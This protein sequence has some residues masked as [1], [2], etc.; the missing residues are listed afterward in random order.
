MFE[1]S[2]SDQGKTKN[3]K[4]FS[5]NREVY[6]VLSNAQP[7]QF[8]DVELEKKGE[9]WEW[10]SIKTAGAPASEA[11][12]PG[13]AT[14]AASQARPAEQSS[15][16]SNKDTSIARAVALKAAVDFLATVAPAKAGKG[17]EDLLKLSNDLE[18]YLLN[19]YT[20]KGLE[21]A[22]KA[23]TVK[24]PVDPDDDIPF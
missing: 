11:P 12:S 20:P 19:G 15:Y 13:T 6:P 21:A 17:V 7:G 9:Y 4:F 24:A 14:S 10:I 8:Y 3:K 23:D 22:V 2:Y 16:Q 18:G 1:L 5:F